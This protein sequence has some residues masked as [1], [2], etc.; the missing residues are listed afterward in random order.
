MLGFIRQGLEDFSISR[1]GATWGIPFP[2][3]ADGSSA[4]DAA[5]NGDPTAGT[6]YVWYD[7]LINYLTGA[8]FPADPEGRP[9]WPAD[10]HIIGKDII[11]FH[12]VYWPAF[13]GNVAPPGK[14]VEVLRDGQA[15]R[16]LDPNIQADLRYA[17]LSGDKVRWE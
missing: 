9:W 6:I 3:R 10:L 14:V 15:P 16:K 12:A 8:G 1:E 7:A 2:I 5:G 4:V 13:L 17:L 11:R